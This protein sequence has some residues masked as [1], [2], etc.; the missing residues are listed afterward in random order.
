MKH[1]KVSGDPFLAEVDRVARGPLTQWLKKLDY[2]PSRADFRV[3]YHWALSIVADAVE[4]V[5]LSRMP[6]TDDRFQF[7]SGTARGFRLAR[8][9]S[10]RALARCIS[11]DP[12]T[13]HSVGLEDVQSKLEEI[14]SLLLEEK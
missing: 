2:H 14:A 8:G 10:V 13:F 4:D 6:L 3:F 11:E 9:R 1:I 12:N 5:R 7:H